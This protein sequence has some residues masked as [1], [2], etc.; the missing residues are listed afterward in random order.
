M[1]IFADNCHLGDAGVKCIAK[2]NFHNL[3]KLRIGNDLTSSRTNE[4]G[5]NGF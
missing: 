1:E 2:S 5:L 3:S 4:I